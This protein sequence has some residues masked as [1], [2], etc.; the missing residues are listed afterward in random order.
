M[1][2]RSVSSQKCARQLA[3]PNQKPRAASSDHGQAGCQT[4]YMKQ[5]SNSQAKMSS[6]KQTTDRNLKIIAEHVVQ[7]LFL[8]IVSGDAGWRGRLAGKQGR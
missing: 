6:A 5:R 1:S 8:L 2:Q 4:K 3:K 7:Q